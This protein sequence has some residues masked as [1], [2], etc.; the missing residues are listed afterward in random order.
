MSANRPDLISIVPIFEL[1][2]LK[3]SGHFDFPRGKKHF[4]GGKGGGGGG[5]TK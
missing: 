1:Q 3:K 2:N 4:L 5:G